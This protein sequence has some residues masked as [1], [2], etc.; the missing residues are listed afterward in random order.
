MDVLKILQDLKVKAVGLKPNTEELQEGYFV[1]FRNIGLPIRARDF[2]DGLE[3]VF[4]SIEDVKGDDA[5]LTPSNLPKDIGDGVEGLDESKVEAIDKHSPEMNY[6]RTFV[7]SDDKIRMNE[8]FLVEPGTSKIAGS[9]EA[10]LNAATIDLANQKKNEE[11]EKAFKDLEALKTPEMLNKMDRAESKYRNALEDLVEKYTESKFEGKIGEYKWKSLGKMYQDKRD[12]TLKEYQLASQ[13]YNEITAKL[14]SNGVDPA[15]FLIS[16]AKTKFENWKIQLGTYE[17]VPY[18]FMSPSDWYSEY[19]RGWTKYNSKD[20]NTSFST[21]SSSKD[22]SGNVAFN[23]GLWSIGPKGGYSSEKSN[24]N[25]D[26]NSAE[27]EFEYLIVKIHRPW[28]DTSFLNA[29]NW[30]LKT[31]GTEPYPEGCISNGTY[32]Q[33]F[34][35]SNESVFLPSVITSLILIKDFKIKS[36]EI[37]S[38][39]EK[40]MKSWSAGGTIGIGPFSLGS[41]YSS[42]TDN[43]KKDFELNQE[44]LS[45]E[46]I[47][48]IGYVSEI[49][50]KSPQ[51]ASILGDTE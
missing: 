43:E 30:Y 13:E 41:E 1:S 23:L 6:L 7:L 33:E 15:T 18:T 24:V 12:R 38:S 39:I 9:Y 32:S 2:Q 4:L 40:E 36:A 27:I 11:V 47:Q 51:M 8:N 42:S 25:F 17:S 22:F 46:G 28:M 14:N 45:C 35:S 10:I 37:K 49:L 16:K 48:L 29:K 26:L 50:P 44:E 3:D 5:E 19:A 34:E 20:Y 31:E 21:S